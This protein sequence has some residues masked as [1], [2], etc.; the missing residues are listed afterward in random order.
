MAASIRTATPTSPTYTFLVRRRLRE[1]CI[2]V[3][4][5]FLQPDEDS[6][7]KISREDRIR[8]LTAVFE[9]QRVQLHSDLED[10]QIDFNIIA[11]VIGELANGAYLPDHRDPRLLIDMEAHLQLLA[12]AIRLYKYNSRSLDQDIH[13]DVL[14]GLK[15]LSDIIEENR[16]RRDEQLRIE[17][18]DVIFLLKHC[19]FLLLSI[20]N[21]GSLG[22]TVA[23]RAILAVDD[24]H[25]GDKHPYQDLKWVAAGILNRH[26]LRPRWHDEY[27]HLEDACRSLFVRD[28]RL[29][30]SR[31]RDTDIEALLE[32]ATAAAHI[33]REA[34]EAHLTQPRQQSRVNMIIKVV[35]SKA[36]KQE[37]RA[38]DE[39]IDFFIYGILH[40]LYQLSF[41]CRKRSRFRCFV[42]YVRMIRM[43]LE[44]SHSSA[45]I[46]R[47]KASDLWN[48]M[49]DLGD[50]DGLRY[51]EDED[52]QAIHCWMHQHLHDSEAIEYSVA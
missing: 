45:V 34:M 39:Q 28:L 43:V 48:R 51:G 10:Q 6:S 27:I 50:K 33:L 31:D 37:T 24:V 8:A 47:W 38:H 41:H 32:E 2:A 26:R 19:Q 13:H 44:R 15:R 25:N 29:G 52:R 16:S 17:E 36:T 3:L 35:G 40:L 22:R 12:S 42:E 14:Q 21:S 1:R 9:L 46:L 23:R 7:I 30:G 11:N 20:D 4:E 5:N 18:F 49:I